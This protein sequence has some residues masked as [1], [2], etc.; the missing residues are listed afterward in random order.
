M[1]CETR[2][3]YVCAEVRCL[4]VNTKQSL[5]AS[6]IYDVGFDIEVERA[7]INQIYLVNQLNIE[8]AYTAQET[9]TIE[10][11]A[12]QCPLSGGDAVYKARAMMASIAPEQVFDD[13]ILCQLNNENK[14]VGSD[15][16]KRETELKVQPNPTA[17]IFEVLVTTTI[18]DLKAAQL[19]M[20]MYNSVGQKILEQATKYEAKTIIDVSGFD[21]G[22]YTI[23]IR[24]DKGVLL[25]SSKVIVVSN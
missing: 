1:I 21:A 3:L 24:N 23:V 11:I 17:D 25:R 15:R 5:S 10:D 2:E 22:I 4:K 18:Q 12:N 14:R 7:G 6:E 19:T 8:N 20:T 13:V 9:L 16:E